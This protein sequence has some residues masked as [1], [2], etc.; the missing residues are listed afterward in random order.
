MDSDQVENAA[1]LD[2]LKVSRL[3]WTSG[4][5]LKGVVL[6]VCVCVAAW[7]LC[8]VLR[9]GDASRFSQYGVFESPSGAKNVTLLTEPFMRPINSRGVANDQIISHGIATDKYTSHP[10]PL[11]PLF[12]LLRRIRLCVYMTSSGGR[13]GD[14][15]VC[16]HHGARA[17][18]EL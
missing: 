2:A 9:C 1:V 13:R 8:V 10:A 6:L 16:T 12:Q 7:R 3:E 17:S 14:H 18:S 11:R 4:N 5:C 15:R